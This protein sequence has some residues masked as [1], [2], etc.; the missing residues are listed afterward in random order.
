VGGM[1]LL[2]KS[3]SGTKSVVYLE[4]PKPFGVIFQNGIVRLLL[5]D[6]WNSEF[7]DEGYTPPIFSFTLFERTLVHALYS[8]LCRM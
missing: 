8:Y 4:S 3:C 2:Q 7:H 5:R 1:V 6:G